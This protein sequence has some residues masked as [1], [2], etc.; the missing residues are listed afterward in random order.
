LQAFYCLRATVCMQPAAFID[1]PLPSLFWTPCWFGSRSPDGARLR[2]LGR[3]R[4]RA[5]R[6]RNTYESGPR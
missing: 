4:P 6:E 5:R 3:P 1:R 2:F